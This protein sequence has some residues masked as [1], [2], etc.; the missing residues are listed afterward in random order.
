[1][2]RERILGRAS[3]VVVSLDREHWWRPRPE[4]FLRALDR[5]PLR[6]PESA[7]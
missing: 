1:V 7:E 3:A 6:P 5:E 4:R 2:P